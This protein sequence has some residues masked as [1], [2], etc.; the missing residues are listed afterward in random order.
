[1]LIT[2]SRK[3]SPKTRTF[4]RNLRKAL[5]ED[6]INRGKMSLRDVL[7]KAVQSNSD[8]IIVISEIK[9]NPSRIEILNSDGNSLLSLN[10]TSSI[11]SSSGKI[12]REKL[13]IRCDNEDLREVIPVIGIAEE[14]NEQTRSISNSNIVWIKKGPKNTIGMIEFY[15]KDGNLASPKIYIRNIIQMS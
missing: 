6:Y 9:G 15:D 14:E 4:A 3:P 12:N 13:R 2:T 11:I 10:I 7:L 8:K 5:N 1:M